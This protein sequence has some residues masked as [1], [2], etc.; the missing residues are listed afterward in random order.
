M[1][2]SLGVRVPSLVPL[3]AAPRISSRRKPSPEGRLT[4]DCRSPDRALS[5]YTI[6]PMLVPPN[7]DGDARFEMQ[8]F[9]DVL[10]VLAF[11]VGSR[12]REIDAAWQPDVK[13][14]L[15]PIRKELD[16]YF[17]GRLKK[18]STPGAFNFLHCT[19]V[20]TSRA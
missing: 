17:A 7:A 12:P 19:P 20:A 16:Q 14:V 18:F 5:D 8:F 13:G 9:Q 11:G 4:F 10:H 1:E 15:G 2:Q 3:M 6:D